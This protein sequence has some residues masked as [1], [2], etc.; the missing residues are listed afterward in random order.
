M[1]GRSRVVDL[2]RAELARLGA[3]EIRAR[4]L[5]AGLRFENEGENVVVQ[6]LKAAKA[7]RTHYPSDPTIWNDL[8]EERA[9]AEGTES[10]QT[11]RG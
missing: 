6:A 3:S 10:S 9:S 1:S 5:E 4:L 7:C 8:Y 2:D 11:R